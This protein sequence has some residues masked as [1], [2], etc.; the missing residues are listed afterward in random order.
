MNEPNKITLAEALMKYLP[1]W[2]PIWA[3]E[4][5]DA[6]NEEMEWPPSDKEER[7]GS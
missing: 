1:E 4:M 3:R 5:T 7:P 6:A 2:G